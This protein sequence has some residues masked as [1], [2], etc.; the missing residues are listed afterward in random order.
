MFSILVEILEIMRYFFSKFCNAKVTTFEPQPAIFNILKKNL[1]LNAVNAE[2][3]NFALGEYE[4][5]ATI[6][7]YDSSN[8]GATALMPTAEGQ[9]PIRSV[10]SLLYDDVN[11]MKIDVEGFEESVLKGARE[12]IKRNKPIIW[13]E[14][15]P[16]NYEKIAKLLEAYSYVLKEQMTDTDFI[17]VSQSQERTE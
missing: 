17:F 7:K 14:I 4:G 12:T 13:I 15:F 16:Q 11:F 9:L 5:K 6:A 8:T 1:E 2:P 3:C 10:D